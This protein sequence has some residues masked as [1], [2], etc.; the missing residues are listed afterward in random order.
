MAELSGM[1]IGLL[2]VT[3]VGIIAFSAM[4]E[5]A[6]NNSLQD[7]DS[8]KLS[9]FNKTAQLYS[10]TQSIRA[11]TNNASINT[12]FLDII[13]QYITSGFQVMKSAAVSVNILTDLSDESLERADIG[14]A[15]QYLKTLI[16]GIIIITIFLGVLISALVKWKL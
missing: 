6:V 7:Y 10:T 14:Y 9:T 16:G 4:G 13:G 1:I 2:V 5:I 12:G 11:Q 3:F 15:G 8:T